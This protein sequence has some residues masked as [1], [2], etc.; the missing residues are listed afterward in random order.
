MNKIL[1][2]LVLIGAFAFTGCKTAPTPQQQALTVAVIKTIAQVAVSTDLTTRPQDKPVILA[3]ELAFTTLSGSTN[4]TAAQID[5]V[6]TSLNVGGTLAQ[7]ATS[8]VLALLSLGSV[9]ATSGSTNVVTLQADAA[10]LA[11]GIAAGAVG[12]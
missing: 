4:I 2:S 5:G 9:I 1:A 11:S 7:T 12:H 8:D 3:A 6:L 10:A